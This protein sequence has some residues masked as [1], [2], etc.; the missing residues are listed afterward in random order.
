M[1]RTATARAFRASVAKRLEL[2]PNSFRLLCLVDGTKNIDVGDIYDS[3]AQVYYKYRVYDGSELYVEKVD[4]AE[5]QAELDAMNAKEQA[6]YE[7]ELA[8]SKADAEARAQ[9]LAEARQAQAGSGNDGD[10]DGPADDHDAG[11]G[12]NAPTGPSEDGDGDDDGDDPAPAELFGDLG[13]G[14]SAMGS[15]LAHGPGGAGTGGSGTSHSTSIKMMPV[16]P[17]L[18]HTHVPATTD[19]SG[20]VRCFETMHRLVTLK[21]SQPDAVDATLSVPFDTRRT[22]GELKEELAKLVGLDT[23][24]FNIKRTSQAGTCRHTASGRSGSLG[25]GVLASWSRVWCLP[26]PLPCLG[27]GGR[28]GRWA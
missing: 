25:V 17:P 11:G 23:S 18:V 14:S 10:A 20:A 22:V 2:E 6:K 3:D 5:I 4:P 26:A 13:L 16:A 28:E 21:V 8:T 27:E 19:N 12:N 1:S 24:E 15:Y 7:T 9:V